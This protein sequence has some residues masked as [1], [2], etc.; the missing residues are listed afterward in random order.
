MEDLIQDDGM[1]T[2]ELIELELKLKKFAH[3]KTMMTNFKRNIITRKAHLE[4]I[5]PLKDV[6]MQGIMAL[7]GTDEWYKFSFSQLIKDQNVSRGIFPLISYEIKR[8][9][10]ILCRLMYSKKDDTTGAT[11]GLE[12]K[13][14]TT[15]EKESLGF[16][17]PTVAY[18]LDNNDI[19]RLERCYADDNPFQYIDLLMVYDYCK[20]AGMNSHWVKFEPTLMSRLKGMPVYN[21]LTVMQSFVEKELV[22]WHVQQQGKYCLELCHLVNGRYSFEKLKET[23]L[24]GAIK[25]YQEPKTKKPIRTRVKKSLLN[26][27]A[28]ATSTQRRKKTIEDESAS[29]LSVANEPNETNKIEEVA[30]IEMPEAEITLSLP[31]TEVDREETP[32]T[33]VTAPMPEPTVDITPPETLPLTPFIEPATSEELAVTNNVNM[34]SQADEIPNLGKLKETLDSVVAG[35]QYWE[36]EAH[37]LRS[38]A[39]TAEDALQKLAIAED[40][41]SKAESDCSQLTAELEQLKQTLQSREEE[42]QRMTQK[43]EIAASRAAT[44]EESTEKAKNLS[45]KLTYELVQSCKVSEDALENMRGRITLIL[46]K[47]SALAEF[48]NN[49]I[50]LVNEL[51]DVTLD[52]R[53]EIINSFSASV[54]DKAAASRKKPSPV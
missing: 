12:F 23:A 22:Y 15:E 47:N 34:M 11:H 5:A 52:T 14:V 42:L 30:N 35:I 48:R 25:E 2:E 3:N 36:K 16:H 24:N 6:V 50:R 37:N 53:N 33:P 51:S 4:K 31:Q 46:G 41:A 9:P 8:E 29:P 54:R 40:R 19:E 21:I 18:G 17:L 39:D 10:N 49:P 27:E 43:Y 44:L 26:N 32:V 28:K 20:R 1:M 45:D 38:K 13:Y 7:Q